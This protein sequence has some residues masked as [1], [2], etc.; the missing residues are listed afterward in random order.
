MAEVLN[1][2][3]GWVP[4]QFLQNGPNAFIE[5]VYLGQRTLQEPFMRFDLQSCHKR[6]LLEYRLFE[7]YC[8]TRRDMSKSVAGMVFHMSRCG[9][10]LTTQMLRHSS[11]HVVIA[12]ADVLGQFLQSFRGDK[13]EL[14]ASLRNIIA[15]LADT[16][17]RQGQKLVIKW[18]SWNI[19]VIDA[20]SE[21]IPDVPICY[22]YRSPQEVLVSL[23]RQH[24]EWMDL[25]TIRKLHRREGYFSHSNHQNPYIELLEA[26]GA[27]H[28][29][30]A[31]L[32]ARLIGHCC[33]RAIKHSKS[34]LMVD[35]RDMPDAVFTQIAPHF[36]IEMSGV[37]KSRAR[38]ESKWDT[39]STSGA[40]QFES[41]SQ[42]KMSLATDDITEYVQ[43]YIEPSLSL[44]IELSHNN[45]SEPT[46]QAKVSERVLDEVRS[47]SSEP[48]LLD[49]SPTNQSV[50]IKWL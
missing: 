35:Y 32:T 13:Q 31:E 46:K 2:E 44:L 16:L 28:V 6:T 37:E 12:E 14:V 8:D 36:A 30:N 23:I 20:I 27:E 10:T 25:A 4:S 42:K 29:S 21:A 45:I 24:A 15:L 49:K 5:M 9:S 41:D 33:D 26:S 39:K 34:L 18:S 48:E 47:H 17:C 1:I 22:Q 7:G 43:A 38:F 40:K 11:A 50:P 3:E 19:Y